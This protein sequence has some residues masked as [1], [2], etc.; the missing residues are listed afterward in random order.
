MEYWHSSYQRWISQ[1]LFSFQWFFIISVMF[2]LYI[3]WIKLVDKRRLK[4][5]LLFGSFIS[6]VGAFIDIV[7]V[8][9]GLWEYKVR[10]F[11]F[12]PALFP[13]DYTIVPILYMLVFQYTS[14]WRG[15]LI[16]S[17]LAS[18]IN[19]FAVNPI[20]VMVGILRYRKFNYFYLFIVIFVLTTIIK[21]IYN[22]V[23]NIQQRKNGN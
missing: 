12:S 16:G 7:G 3:V 19:C 23:S 13:F 4:D 20:Y 15:Y 9:T 5:L 14:T 18:A 10:L 21:A 22:W 6:V 17:L 8:S 1:E 11:P 2:I